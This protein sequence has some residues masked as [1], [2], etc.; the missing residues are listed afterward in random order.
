M[1]R[2][3]G[4]GDHLTWAVTTAGMWAEV[5]PNWE[6][7]ELR[8]LKH[9]L[10][11]LSCKCT[12]C[13]K[14]KAPSTVLIL[15]QNDKQ[16]QVKETRTRLLDQFTQVNRETM[17]TDHNSFLNTISKDVLCP[18]CFVT[19]NLLRGVVLK[20]LKDEESETKPEM[21]C[22]D[23]STGKCDRRLERS[24]SI[25]NKPLLKFSNLTLCDFISECSSDLSVS[26]RDHEQKRSPHQVKFVDI[27]AQEKAQ[28][29]LSGGCMCM[30]NF[31]D[32]IRPPLTSAL[33]M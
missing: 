30:E 7:A 15:S 13:E 28:V 6:P 10:A 21:F 33:Y 32:S 1:N 25:T 17:V 14:S 26:V 4:F 31:I 12:T 2:C 22:C 3:I 29:P 5:E 19:M 18:T 11:H 20:V 23:K 8:K 27:D 24:T 16:V 9:K